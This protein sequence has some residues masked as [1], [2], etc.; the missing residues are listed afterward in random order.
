M[1]AQFYMHTASGEIWPAASIP[2]ARLAEFRPYK[3]PIETDHPC[4]IRCTSAKGPLCNCQCGGLNH[5]AD[6][7]IASGQ[8]GM[9]E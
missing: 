8:L 5:G 1:S 7:G 3:G 6:H 9:F 2:T 4:D